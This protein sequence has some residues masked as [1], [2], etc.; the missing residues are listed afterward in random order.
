MP[1]PRPGREGRHLVQASATALRFFVYAPG[2]GRH[3]PR[4]L[5]LDPA[6]RARRSPRSPATRWCGTWPSVRAAPRGIARVIV[7]TDDERI[8]DAV[9]GRGVEAVM[10]RATIRAAPIAWPRSPRG[11]AADVVVNVQGDLPLLDPAMVERSSARMADDPALPMATLATP[12]RD[13]A[14]WR[15][16]HVVKVVIGSRRARALLLAQPDPVRSRR[17]A[18]PDE[19]FGLAAHRALRLPP[20]RPA[21]L[22][23]LPPSPL[24]R[25]EQLEQLRA[26]EHGIAIGVVDVARR[27][28]R[29]SRWTRRKIW[30][31]RRALEPMPARAPAPGSR[32]R[33]VTMQR[34]RREDEVHLRD[35]RRR[36]VARQGPRVG[37]DRRAAR[38]RAG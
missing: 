11:L 34:S 13:E 14:E 1:P 7:A 23:A 17:R 30:S 8:R 38:E 28:R 25:R 35:R 10:T 36:L 9:A 2:D 4:A 6:S 37:L 26:L 15:S 19:P 31:A 27:R 12:L 20:R 3:H 21:A 5:S 22:A 29:S 18:A 33:A 16:P 24:E 32:G